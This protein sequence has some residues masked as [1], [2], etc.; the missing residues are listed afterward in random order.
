MSPRE[1]GATHTAVTINN[2]ASF[3]LISVVTMADLIRESIKSIFICAPS[4]HPG[5]TLLGRIRSGGQ[6]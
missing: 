5:S 6:I 1:I 3:V 2:P 4:D